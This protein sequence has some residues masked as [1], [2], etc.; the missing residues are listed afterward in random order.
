MQFIHLPEPLSSSSWEIP[1]WT[2]LQ[3]T[4]LD[5]DQLRALIRDG[6]ERAIYREWLHQREEERL[7]TLHYEKRHVEWLGGRICAKQAARQYLMR[8]SQVRSVSFQ[9]PNLLILNAASGRPFLDNQALPEDMS[10]PHLSISHSR[11]YA[12]AMAASACCGIDIQAASEALIRVKDRFCS[13]EEEDILVP[14][15]KQQTDSTCLTLLWAAKEAVKKSASFEWM[16]G[17]LDL[18]LIHIETQPPGCFLFTLAFQDH[19]QEKRHRPFH[20]HHQFKVTVGLYQGYGI[21]LCL[22]PSQGGAC[23]A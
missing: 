9:A 4:M 18:A 16:P 12:M 5:L 3:T 20:P 14:A 22:T 21:A 8:A 1:A 11:K 19:H 13:R 10:G 2:Q 6:Q 17:F 7:A 15:L 23:N